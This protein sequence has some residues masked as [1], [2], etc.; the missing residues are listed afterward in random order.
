[1]QRKQLKSGHTVGFLLQTI[2]LLSLP[3]FL[4]ACGKMNV[5]Q[6][7]QALTCDDSHAFKANRNKNMGCYGN[8]GNKTEWCPVS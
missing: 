2:V 6:V 5:A 7:E 8:G 1:M 4:G 3:L